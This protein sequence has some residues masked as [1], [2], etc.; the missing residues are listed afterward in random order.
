MRGYK[1]MIVNG[2]ALVLPLVDF[3]VNNGSV[4][5]AALGPNGATAL[6]L[7]ALVNMVLRWV[8]TTPVFRND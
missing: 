7:L 4:V 5:G 8:T 3:A 1:T 6:S 2:A